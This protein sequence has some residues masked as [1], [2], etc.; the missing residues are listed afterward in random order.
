MPPPPPA[1]GGEL[2]AGGPPP[3]PA[4]AT[5]SLTLDPNLLAKAKADNNCKPGDTYKLTVTAQYNDKGGFDI[6][7]AD[8]M[9]PVDKATGPVDDPDVMSEDDEE[10]ALGYKRPQ[11]SMAPPEFA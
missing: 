3:S 10:S 8:R 11:K 6:V 2:G 4:A 5:N 9:Q 7:D 1:P